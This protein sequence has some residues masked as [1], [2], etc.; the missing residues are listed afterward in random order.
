MSDELIA[1]VARRARDQRTQTDMGS[2]SVP[3]I[4]PR[5]TDSAAA[6]S[7]NLLGFAVPDLLKAVYRQVG[8]GGFGPGYG[9]IGL[10]GG[11]ED[12]RGRNAVQLYELYSSSD[13]EDPG[14]KWPEALLPICHWG[15]AIYSCIECKTD[16]FP[17]VVFDPN[18][19]DESWL[20]CFLAQQRN[21]ESWLSAWA[22][23]LKLWNEMYG[24]R[25]EI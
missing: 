11:A 24:E 18:M 22:D 25:D 5:L 17:I 16:G 23:G 9:L 13:P 7:E 4:G 3:I 20:R 14:W 10:I 21:L 8:N 19:H 6:T 2:V 1:R 12:D 15:C